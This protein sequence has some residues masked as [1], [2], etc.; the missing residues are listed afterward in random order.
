M[1]VA[2]AGVP[3]DVGT[4]EIALH[5][6]WQVCQVRGADRPS[7]RGACKQAID[8]MF[9]RRAQADRPLRQ[10]AKDDARQRDEREMADRFNV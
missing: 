6:G 2:N 4:S 1:K 10:E 8:V 3:D 7:G 9:V 5:G